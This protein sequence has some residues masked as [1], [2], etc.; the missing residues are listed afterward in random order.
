MATTLEELNSMKEETAGSFVTAVEE[1]Q[2]DVRN[3]VDVREIKE[4]AYAAGVA[5]AGVGRSSA[6]LISSVGSSG[7][8]Y[9]QLG[10]T[11]GLVAQ[12]VLVRKLDELKSQ[13]FE[14]R[15]VKLK[16]L[17][18]S[19]GSFVSTA[20]TPDEFVETLTANTSKTV[21]RIP[22][23]LKKAAT[24]LAVE[25]G[26][27][28]RVLG[29]LASLKE[30]QALSKTLDSIYRMYS[31]VK[32]IADK[33]EPVFPI[34]EI[35]VSAAMIW[36]TGG[37]AAAK[38][39]SESAQLAMQEL[40]KI[41]PLIAKP[42][43]DY[44]Y[45]KDIR[46]PAMLLGAL[47]TMSSQEASDRFAAA[48]QEAEEY[49]LADDARHAEVNNSLKFPGA[50][51]RLTSSIITKSS[52]AQAFVEKVVGRSPLASTLATTI[53]AANA[54]AERRGRQTESYQYTTRKTLA[55]CI[56]DFE[57]R[58]TDIRRISR[59]IVDN[60]DTSAGFYTDR[61][62]HKLVVAALAEDGCVVDVD[63]EAYDENTTTRYPEGNRLAFKLVNDK[64]IGLHYLLR[65]ITGEW[66]ATLQETIPVID[67]YRRT[68]TDITNRY[69]DDKEFDTIEI[70]PK[71]VIEDPDAPTP[72]E[73][74]V[75]EEP[76]IIN[77]AVACHPIAEYLYNTK[78]RVSDESNLIVEY[79]G[80]EEPTAPGLLNGL[81]SYK[82]QLE[83]ATA[84][85]MPAGYEKFNAVVQQLNKVTNDNKPTRW[86]WTD[87]R[88]IIPGRSSVIDLGTKYYAYHI[89]NRGTIV[90]RPLATLTPGYNG[91]AYEYYNEALT[92]VNSLVTNYTIP[93]EEW[94]SY[95]TRLSSVVV[96]RPAEVKVTQQPVKY[97]RIVGNNIREIWT[98]KKK[99]A[100]VTSIAY[101]RGLRYPAKVNALEVIDPTYWTNLNVMIEGQRWLY[102]DTDNP[103]TVIRSITP[104]AGYAYPQPPT[105]DYNGNIVSRSKGSPLAYTTGP[106]DT[107]P[108]EQQIVDQLAGHP[109]IN[110]AVAMNPDKWSEWHAGTEDRARIRNI[111]IITPLALVSKAGGRNNFEPT[112]LYSP[113]GS[114]E[115]PEAMWLVSREEL[116]FDTTTNRVFASFTKEGRSIAL[117]VTDV[118]HVDPEVNYLMVKYKNTLHYYW[119]G[120]EHTHNI[121]FPRVEIV[122][123]S[124]W[125]YKLE[126]IQVDNATVR[127]FWRPLRSDQDIQLG[128]R[129]PL[130]GLA[131]VESQNKSSMYLSNLEDSMI[132]VNIPTLDAV[133]VDYSYFNKQG[134]SYEPFNRMLTEAAVSAYT[135]AALSQL[136]VITDTVDEDILM[137]DFSHLL[138]PWINPYAKN[139]VEG[140]LLDMMGIEKIPAMIERFEVLAKLV[141]TLQ[142]NKITPE[143]CHDADSKLG[144]L[145]T[146]WISIGDDWETND[147]TDEV[148]GD[149]VHRIK[150]DLLGSPVHGTYPVRFLEGDEKAT[151]RVD[152]LYYQRYMFLNARMHR[153]DGALARAG[154]LLYNWQIVKD[155]RG[156]QDAQIENFTDFLDAL[157]IPQMDELMYV[158]PNSEGEEGRFYL[159]A[160]LDDIRA[161]IS[162]KCMLVC[163]PC[164]VKDSCPFYDESTILYMYVPPAT[165][166]DLYVKDNELDL[167]VYEQDEDGRE[168]LNI[169]GS[170]GT[171][172]QAADMRARH[173]VYTEIIH[174]P[175]E[176]LNLDIVRETISDKLDGFKLAENTYVDGLDWLHGGRYGSL[177]LHTE[178]G[179]VV[180]DLNKHRYLYD[181]LFI[182]DQETNIIYGETASQYPVEFEAREGEDI[183][184][185]EGA[186]RL[187]KPLD[188]TFSKDAEGRSIPL[189]QANGES[190]LWLISDDEVDVDGYP[191]TPMIYINKLKYLHYDFEFREDGEQ[192]ES[193][194]DPRY[195]GAADIA[196]WLVNSYKWMDPTEDKYWMPELTKVVRVSKG[197][198]DNAV[199]QLPGRPRV[200][201]V[202]DPLTNK[203]PP[204]EDILRGKP[205]VRN[206]INFV[207]KLRLQLKDIRWSKTD[208]REEIEKR[209]KQLASMRTNLRLA[210]VKM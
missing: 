1:T 75:N 109:T 186:V 60:R 150:T 68:F 110:I 102:I 191:M 149:F 121:Y 49:L 25:V 17:L 48:R 181:A 144:N 15:T 26:S 97:M 54:W 107:P 170:N 178:E 182:R 37:S 16:S 119:P 38:M 45:N 202:V 78:A 33:F 160:L 196:Q 29:S 172:L 4:D 40:K 189:S 190:E 82:E 7:D 165:T 32:K 141:W 46:I 113:G 200:A 14:M 145:A 148:L 30:V 64:I 76:S 61:Q 9:T 132:A 208:N 114:T 136:P 65:G 11:A 71:A 133:K 85:E 167:L 159:R 56:Q 51:N 205:Y 174:D 154:F 184:H 197:S 84:E 43:K 111:R 103:T 80:N 156:F 158:P 120:I 118:H 3:A 168:Y 94:N 180:S 135:A 157:P 177:V 34:I 198:S 58:D 128:P 134:T 100:V 6:A 35:T 10:E 22:V 31:A 139:A 108:A 24:E 52:L 176:E 67:F 138:S 199:I 147:V 96:R 166:L 20:T 123:G 27:D 137:R 77:M 185:Y 127:D 146:P 112:I 53:V 72:Y 129:P 74:L 105:T 151:G 164:P 140:Y 143:I 44:I 69:T 86:V 99:K 63:K 12:E 57:L 21:G 194:D 125:V 93:N 89:R 130:R 192:I 122:G 19:T 193:A 95:G 179:R 59:L 101:Q 153:T 183:V 87:E 188:V 50:Y 73:L 152:S 142:H 36:C 116:G 55:S 41:V 187:K 18:N 47:D 209:K 173:K 70:I 92:F 117:Q 90:G 175:D 8:A 2:Q 79:T 104:N 126:A 88:E 98:S 39:S 204:I 91:L 81:F 106:Y 13:L 23:L 66:R 206:Y 42:M 5:T 203:E 28:P 171:R 155:A 163:A 195:P 169:T 161:Q 201:D 162:D 62:M 131:S 207:R 83:E 115:V 124:C 210:L